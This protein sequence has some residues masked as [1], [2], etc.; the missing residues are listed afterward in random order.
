MKVYTADVATL[1]KEA[2]TKFE[3]DFG[4]RVDDG[5][6]ENFFSELTGCIN[7]IAKTTQIN[8]DTLYK[9]YYIKLNSYKLPE[10]GYSTTYLNA[11]S[12]YVYELNYQDKYLVVYEDE[13][14]IPEFPQHHPSFPATPCYRI[15]FP[16]E[17]KELQDYTNLW[18]KDES[19]NVT[20]VHKDRMAWEVFL[21]YN[22]HIKEEIMKGRI[23]IPRLSMISSGNAALS[24]QYMLRKNGLPDLKVLVD[25]G[26]EEKYK[27]ALEHSG[28]DVYYAKLTKRFYSPQDIKIATRNVDGVE[29]YSDQDGM[30]DLKNTFYDWLS[31]EVLNLNPQVVLTP[32]GTGDLYKNI[33]NILIQELKSKRPS[34]RF[35]GNKAILSNCKFLGAGSDDKD[36]GFKMLYTPFN[37]FKHKT[38]QEIIKNFHKSGLIQKESDVVEVEGKYGDLAFE[39]AG[40]VGITCEYSG[41]AGLALFLQIKKRISPK[42]KVIIINTGKMRLDLF[43]N[44]L[45]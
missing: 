32:F 42:E 2:I 43:K 37:S 23:Q 14:E 4:R 3:N 29:L 8:S 19:V 6:K 39:I 17:F 1:L 31:Y 24:I 28:C 41:I 30:Y 12:Q 36:S 18:I 5:N 27:I 35:F 15:I 40:K 25:E 13:N 10:I 38:Q 20:G 9:Q 16:K 11:L 26:L 22:K 34:K 44:K 21:Q 33:L 7:R 45:D